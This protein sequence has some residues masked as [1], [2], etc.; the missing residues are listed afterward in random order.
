MFVAMDILWN[1]KSLPPPSFPIDP[2][3][4]ANGESYFSFLAKLESSKVLLLLRPDEPIAVAVEVERVGLALGQSVARQ[5]GLLLLPLWPPVPCDL[6]HLV[7]AQPIG[8]LL[9]DRCISAR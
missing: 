3:S 7:H 6:G 1:Y 2:I 5:V 8:H 4:R 9:R